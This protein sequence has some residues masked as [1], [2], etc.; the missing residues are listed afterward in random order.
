MIGSQH[1]LH[2]SESTGV[3]ISVLHFFGTAASGIGVQ[4]LRTECRET[5]APTPIRHHCG[6]SLDP[7]WEEKP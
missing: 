6:I 4:S 7:T 1:H 3:L 5:V 2:V